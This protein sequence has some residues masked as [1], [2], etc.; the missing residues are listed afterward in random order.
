MNNVSILSMRIYIQLFII[1]VSLHTVVQAKAL[2][3]ESKSILQKKHYRTQKP[4]K[5]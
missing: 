5:L 1:P 4:K 3:G 2:A